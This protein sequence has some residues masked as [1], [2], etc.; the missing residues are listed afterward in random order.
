MTHDFGSRW[1]FGRLFLAP[2][3]LAFASGAFIL[4]LASL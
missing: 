1:S 3:R 2:H 4:M